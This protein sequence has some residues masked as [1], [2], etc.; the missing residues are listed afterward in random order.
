MPNIPFPRHLAVLILISVACTFAGNHIAARIAFDHGTGVLLAI[1]C[2]SGGTLLVLAT[3]VLLRREPLRLSASA[4]RWQVALGLLMAVQSYCIYSA[5][6]RIPVGLA[7]L[8]M[9]LSPILLAMLTWLLGGPAPSSRDA[10]IMG[11]I[12]IGLVL[13]LNVPAHLLG[14]Q[15]LDPDWILGLLFSFIASTAL[16][17]S[18]WLTDHRLSA[19]SGS[20]RSMLTMAVVFTATALAGASGALSGDFSL[21]A[22][23]TG[24]L[25]LLSLVL[26]YGAAFSVLF[27]LMPRLGMARNAP[28]MNIEPVAGLLFGWLLLGQ[29]LTALQI[30]GGGIVVG[31]ILLLAYRR[32]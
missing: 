2:R 15:G 21:P 24:W 18:F 13:V 22:A 17:C 4:R 26:L 3:L 8:V 19:I 27:S 30:A 7:L 11:L 32:K 29:S 31:G 25:A 28:V 5:V 6:S 23:S 20:V 14:Q 16:A 12:L 1:L 9:N 10:R